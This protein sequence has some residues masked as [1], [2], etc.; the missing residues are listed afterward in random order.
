M[1][2]GNVE[3]IIAP[4]GGI[5]KR[6]FDHKGNIKITENSQRRKNIFYI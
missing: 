1:I 4:N 5:T 2:D 6:W 3:E